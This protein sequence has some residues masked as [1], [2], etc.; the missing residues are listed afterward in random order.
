M[1]VTAVGNQALNSPSY[2]K[3]VW[4]DYMYGG[5]TMGATADDISLIDKQY[6][7]RIK[8]WQAQ[9]SSTDENVYEIE[10]ERYDKKVDK[11]S[12]KASKETGFDGEADNGG[13][14]T[15]T[16]ATYVAGTAGAAVGVA[17]GAVAL[18]SKIEWL[19][20][21][22]EKRSSIYYI[23]VV[24]GMLLATA[25]LLKSAHLNREPAEACNT[26]QNEVLPEA[27]GKVADSQASMDE[28]TEEVAELTDKA[29]TANDEANE[30]MAEKKAKFDMYITS[31]FAL[32][33]KAKDG[34]M[35]SEEKEV[36]TALAAAMKEQGIEI[37][38]IKEDNAELIEEIYGNMET[39]VDVF[40][41][42]V[43]QL[44]EVQGIT[45]FAAGFDEDTADNAR[46]VK[47]STIAGY[48]GSAGVI[49]GGVWG[50][51]HA[52]L[53][54]WEYA[55]GAATVGSGI[56]SGLIFRSVQREQT[57]Y[58]ESAL[59]EITVRMDTQEM[60]VAGL[61][62]YNT[63]IEEYEGNI[64]DT[65]DLEMEVPDDYAAPE[66]QNV[67]VSDPTGGANNGGNGNGLEPGSNGYQQTMG[68]GAN[69]SPI[70]D[71]NK[72]IDNKGEIIVNE[73]GQ[74]VMNPVYQKAIDKVTQGKKLTMDMIPDVL[75]AFLPK[76]FTADNIRTV[77][78]GGQFNEEYAANIVKVMTGNVVDTKTKNASS[79]AT[80]LMR[81]VLNFY[82][83]IFQNA[84]TRGYSTNAQGAQ[85][86]SA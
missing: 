10:D 12:E 42:A 72:P 20:C 83:P 80:K 3:K 60:N 14:N 64:Q 67:T 39:Y 77:Q 5:R 28:T 17:T 73:K 16:V 32:Q 86:V 13:S 59:S 51:L 84:V 57:E 30:G 2:A 23:A 21:L 24:G 61:E 63:Q 18:T 66:A 37:D 76:P 6:K 36:Y 27:Q 85:R 50:M 58:Q 43:E 70:L 47:N 52:G 31:F 1:S 82:Y 11:G 38:T 29:A 69:Y 45:D 49:A 41:A 54:W 8:S 81:K 9:Y 46:N 22:A 7:D 15:G 55:L 78:N 33:Q 53:K 19:S 71:G 35:T 65:A 75:A 4:I 34:T 62:Q 68:Y 48:A 40:D 26:L 74:V 25:I 56:A 44:G 79:E